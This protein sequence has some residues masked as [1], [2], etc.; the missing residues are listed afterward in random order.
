MPLDRLA[1]R[2]KP[3]KVGVRQATAGKT[4]TGPGVMPASRVPRIRPRGL[5]WCMDV[6]ALGQGE[7]DFTCVRCLQLTA[8]ACENPL[9]DGLGLPPSLEYLKFGSYFNHTIAGVK[10]SPSLKELELGEDSDQPIAGVEWPASLLQLMF[11]ANFN[12]P[13]AG[14]KWSPCL[15]QLL[16]GH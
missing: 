5:V 10:W 14:V 8:T 16:F 2:R 1:S 15:K 13:I 7:V 12:Q 6:N 4:T 3:Y 9:P 11:G